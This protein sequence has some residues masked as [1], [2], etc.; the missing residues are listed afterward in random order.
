M[1]RN[2]LLKNISTINLPVVK[3]GFCE[4]I[5]WIYAVTLKA[6]CNK[7]AKAVMRELGEKGVGA[8]PFFYPMHRQPVFNNMGL[9]LEDKLPNSE[10][11]Y[12]K[13]FYI[14]SS[15]T[16]SEQQLTKVAKSLREVLS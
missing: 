4:N 12:K 6:S 13:G 5:Y 14:P 9:F 1:L 16:L 3:T 11:L 10:K 2:T 8:R 7:E 15:L